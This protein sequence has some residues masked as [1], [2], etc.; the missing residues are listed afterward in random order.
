MTAI[1]L[2]FPPRA[3]APSPRAEPGLVLVL[4]VIRIE[5]EPNGYSSLDG[6][7]RRRQREPVVVCTDFPLIDGSLSGG[8][9]D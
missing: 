9:D 5:R 6:T 1:I 2:K 8:A 7:R 4:P 3:P